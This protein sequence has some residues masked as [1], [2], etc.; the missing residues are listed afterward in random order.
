MVYEGPLIQAVATWPHHID[1][2]EWQYEKAFAGN[3][4]FSADLVNCIHKRVKLFLKLCNTTC[5]DRVETGA[6]S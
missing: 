3:P 4:F 1:R 2:F 6:L 5:L